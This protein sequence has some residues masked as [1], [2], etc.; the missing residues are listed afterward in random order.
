MSRRVDVV[1]RRAQRTLQYRAF[2]RGQRGEIDRSSSRSRTELSG[3][4]SIVSCGPAGHILT[5]ICAIAKRDPKTPD[6]PNQSPVFGRNE[7]EPQAGSPTEYKTFAE[8]TIERRKRGPRLPR[9]CTR[10]LSNGGVLWSTRDGPSDS[11]GPPDGLNGALLVF[12]NWMWAVRASRVGHL[13]QL[14]S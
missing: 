6:K 8:R 9:V 13:N 5:A 2:T 11:K 3:S 14:T 12:T 1:P 10:D 7:R 4:P